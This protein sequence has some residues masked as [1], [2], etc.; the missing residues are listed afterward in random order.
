MVRV[1]LH[2]GLMDALLI[3]SATCCCTLAAANQPLHIEKANSCCCESGAPAQPRPQ[4]KSD[5]CCKLRQPYALAGSNETR[6]VDASE[7][8]ALPDQVFENPHLGPG[9]ATHSQF[10]PA[11][12][13]WFHNAQELLRALQSLR[14]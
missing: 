4:P 14:L 7:M 3:H 10:S 13:S 11:A 6:G 8:L 9:L 12:H 5:C 1:L 2:F